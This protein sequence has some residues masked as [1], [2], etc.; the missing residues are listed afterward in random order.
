MIVFLRREA[1][2]ADAA[3]DVAS[4]TRAAATRPRGEPFAAQHRRACRPGPASALSDSCRAGDA[5]FGLRHRLRLIRFCVRARASA[6]A[7]RR[8]ERELRARQMRRSATARSSD[9]PAPA[10]R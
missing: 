7:G 4:P 6:R 3:A 10:S 9:T 1:V 5:A 2:A 8:A